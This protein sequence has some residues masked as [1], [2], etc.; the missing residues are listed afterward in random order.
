MMNPFSL[1]SLLIRALIARWEFLTAREQKKIKYEIH[2]RY[3]IQKNRV[4]EAQKN[5]LDAPARGAAANELRVLERD[6]GVEESY[7]QSI[8]RDLS[9]WSDRDA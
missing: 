2:D 8:S 9:S 4:K 3:E 5:L 6:A 1:L 7:L